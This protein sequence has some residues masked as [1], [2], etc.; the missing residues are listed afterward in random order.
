MSTDPYQSEQGYPGQTSP[1]GM[2]SGT[3]ALLIVLIVLG[4][5]MLLCCG[6]AG[7]FF[8]S[9]GKWAQDAMS[10]DPV[11]IRATTQEMVDMDLPA[12]L[13]PQMMLDMKV[14]FTGQRFMT[15]AVFRDDASDSQL[16][17]VGIGEGMPRQSEEQMRREIQNSLRQQGDSG[18]EEMRVEN[19]RDYE[20]EIQGSR[21]VFQISEGVGRT[22]G[23]PRIQASGV[24]EGKSGPVMLLLDA[25]AEAFSE[26]RV[27]EILDS[28]E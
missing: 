5:L 24:F 9:V 18:V 23:R 6:V 22:S 3:K 27:V 19:A 15:W 8:F 16:L 14:P 26:E 17:L 12:E 10:Q 11:R 20:V 28:I 1:P 25:D 13:Q 4:I 2:S 21:A 7:V